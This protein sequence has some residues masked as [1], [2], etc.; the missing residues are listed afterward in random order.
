MVRMFDAGL[1]EDRPVVVHDR[2][3]TVANAITV[4]RLAG[5]PLFVWLMVGPQA[6]GLAFLTLV[7][8]GTTDWIDGYIARRFD[9]VTRLGQVMDPL[10]DRALLATAGLTMA[11]LGIL[12]WPVIALIVGRDVVLLVAAAVLFR[13]NPQIPVTRL[14][15]FSTAC[16]LIGVPGFL[17]GHMDW[18][19]AAFWGAAGWVFTVAGMITY[20]AAGGSYARA[21]RQ[22]LSDPTTGTDQPGRPT[23]DRSPTGAGE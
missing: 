12:P 2:V 1:R 8:V 4:L 17:L 18:G 21:A 7:V 23:D 9:Q 15:K 10:I 22:R 5:L 20:Y 14:G 13:G 16:L 11:A 3:W 19:G 6:Y